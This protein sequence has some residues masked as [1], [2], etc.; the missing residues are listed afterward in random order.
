MW[1]CLAYFGAIFFS[2]IGHAPELLQTR[3]CQLLFAQNTRLHLYMHKYGQ[4]SAW[5][6]WRASTRYSI[7]LDRDLQS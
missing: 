3:V 7:S 2:R 4:H 6:T 1:V 5:K